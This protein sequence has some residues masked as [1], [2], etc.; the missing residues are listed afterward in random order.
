MEFKDALCV[1]D[2]AEVLMGIYHM[3][4]LKLLKKIFFWEAPCPDQQQ[5]PDTLQTISNQPSSNSQSSSTLQHTRTTCKHKKGLNDASGVPE[6]DSLALEF[7]HRSRELY[8]AH[9]SLFLCRLCKNLCYCN[10]S[11]RYNTLGLREYLL[12]CPALGGV[13]FAKPSECLLTCVFTNAEGTFPTSAIAEAEGIL[14][15]ASSRGR[16][17]RNAKPTSAPASRAS[18]GPA[19]HAGQP[20]IADLFRSKAKGMPDGGRGAPIGDE[21]SQVDDSYDA[22]PDTQIPLLTQTQQQ[23]QSEVHSKSSGKRP[24]VEAGLSSP[25]MGTE[26]QFSIPPSAESIADERDHGDS[27][28]DTLQH[29]EL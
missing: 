22:P 25:V 6:R 23:Q 27:M 19:P 10:K 11:G 20:K 1:P 21:L 7:E 8:E 12:A 14:S 3:P 15:L 2:L 16:A 13:R 24:R 26:S 28:E 4:E 9:K 5:H 17:V 18:S 29:V